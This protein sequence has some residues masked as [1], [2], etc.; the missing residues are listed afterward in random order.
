MTRLAKPRPL[1]GKHCSNGLFL[2]TNTFW[3]A[4]SPLWM[5]AIA[6]TFAALV[7]QLGWSQIYPPLSLEIATFLSITFAASLILFYVEYLTWREPLPIRSSW[8]TRKRV[9]RTTVFIYLIFFIELLHN[10]GVPI[11]MIF[12]G[13]EYDYRNFGIPTLHVAIYGVYWFLCVH[14]FYLWL[15]SR[16]NFYLNCSLLL[17]SINLLIVNRGA[18]IQALLAIVILFV[19]K[20]GIKPKTVTIC[21]IGIAALVWIF[22]V[23][24]DARMRSMGIDPGFTIL[25]I[26][27]ASPRYPVDELGT[28][29]FWFYLYISSPLANWQF[30][31]TSGGGMRA[32][33]LFFFITEIMPDFIGKHFLSGWETRA[34]PELIADALTVSSAFGPAY[35]LKGW[36]G[37]S[38]IYIV[39]V[40]YYLVSRFVFRGSE[41]F[42]SGMSTL[43][44]GAGLMAFE[45][46]L[47]FT[48]LIGPLLVAVVFRYLLHTKTSSPT[49]ASVRLGPN[50]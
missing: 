23:I 38:L 33:W 40:F 39:L 49:V 3:I 2:R 22:G 30:N 37:A 5:Y 13:S 27:D 12:S 14:W 18:F 35:F 44:V 25:A 19:L 45:N 42:A 17:L 24:G 48:G 10:G 20:K 28:G 47:A 36:A 43:A 16:Q 26:G 31:V 29:P 21:L 1:I 41:Y 50:S 6:F 9:L 46:M 7:Y 32:D 11:I 4:T 15:S 8:W 34:S